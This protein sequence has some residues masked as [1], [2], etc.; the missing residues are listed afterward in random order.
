MLTDKIDQ[1]SGSRWTQL[2]ALVDIGNQLKRAGD[3][4]D[5]IEQTLDMGVM[6]RVIEA[7]D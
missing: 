3:K 7:P 2:A 4:L 5:G 6:V 1:A